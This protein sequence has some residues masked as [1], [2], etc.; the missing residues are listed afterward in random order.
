MLHDFYYYDW[1]DKHVEG[2]KKFDACRNRR[3][4]LNN[5]L[6][7]FELNDIEKD[8]IIKH[9]WPLTIKF[10]SYKES[11][12]VTMVDKYC[13]THEVIKKIKRKISKLS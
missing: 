12:I 6:D 10:P 7:I 4:A 13:A 1:R 9:M 11:Y 3:I 8:I 5:A 2:Q